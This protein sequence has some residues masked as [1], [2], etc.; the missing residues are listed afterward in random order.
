MVVSQ[1]NVMKHMMQKSIL[2]G[3]LGKWTYSLVEYELSYE[4]LQAIKGQVALI[5]RSKMTIYAWS[6]RLHGSYSLMILFVHE[7]VE[8]DV[9]WWHQVKKYES[10]LL[11]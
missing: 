9:C 7:E 10:W 3:R 2:N 6:P 5:M 11:G 4:P 1:Y 8:W